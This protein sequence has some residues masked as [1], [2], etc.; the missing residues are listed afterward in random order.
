M[1][2]D[3][4]G[5]TYTVMAFTVAEGSTLDDAK[6]DIYNGK[7]GNYVKGGQADPPGASSVD[8]VFHTTTDPQYFACGSSPASTV[9]LG[10]IDVQ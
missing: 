3:S 10:P 2:K 8:F 6:N 5:A 9:I 1:V 7:F 4:G